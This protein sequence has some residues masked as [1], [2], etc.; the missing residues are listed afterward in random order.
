MSE[1]QVRI[2]LRKQ[3]GDIEDDG[4]FDLS[5]VGGILPSIGDK[6]LNPC[7]AKDRDRKDASTRSMWIVVGRVFNPRDLSGHVALIVEK[8]PLSAEEKAFLPQ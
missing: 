3:G 4:D 7:V 6:I 2:Y 8:R 1:T 5:Y